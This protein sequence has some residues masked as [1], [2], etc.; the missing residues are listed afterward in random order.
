MAVVRS[1]KTESESVFFAHLEAF[2][3]CEKL[4]KN[5]RQMRICASE[6]GL[7]PNQII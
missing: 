2:S 6:F 4:H 5:V 7:S 3:H 1:F